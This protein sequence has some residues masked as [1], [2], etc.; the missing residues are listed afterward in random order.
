MEASSEINTGKMCTFMSRQHSAQQNH[1]QDFFCSLLANTDLL[2]L[3]FLLLK[4]RSYM[5]PKIKHT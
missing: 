3:Q 4:H 5:L 1:N 2:T